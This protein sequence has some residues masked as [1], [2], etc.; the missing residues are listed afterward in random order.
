MK[1]FVAIDDGT[2]VT[3][4]S[5]E[6]KRAMAYIRSLENLIDVLLENG[7]NDLVSDGG[8]T[9]LMLWRHEARR[10]LGLV[11]P[12]KIGERSDSPCT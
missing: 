4:A 2:K 8:D 9:V 1:A 5:E 12:S 10:A 7:P 3:L 6:W 11:A